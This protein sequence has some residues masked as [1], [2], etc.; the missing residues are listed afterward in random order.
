MLVQPGIL[1]P[2]AH[3]LNTSFGA[4]VLIIGLGQTGFETMALLHDMLRHS[5]SPRDLQVNTRTLAIA[6]RRSMQQE[7]LLHREARL[8]LSIDAIRWSDVPGRYKALGVSRWWPRTPFNLELQEN[9]M[10]TRAF[11][12]LL[13]WHNAQIVGEKL[14]QLTE[15]LQISSQR[16]NQPRLVMV[17]GSLGEAESSGM[18]FDVVGRI[19]ALLA[20][21]P[22]TIAGVF[23]TATDSLDEYERLKTMANAYATLKELDAFNLHPETYRHEFP[24]A[25]TLPEG[26][27]KQALD[28]ICL[29]GDAIMPA[30]YVEG[31]LAEF[32]LT[33]L[34]HLTQK[35]EPFLP[36]LSPQNQ[37]SRYT[38]YTNFGVAKLGLPTRAALELQAI[39]TAR[40][41]LKRLMD[42][43][44]D[45]FKDWTQKIITRAHTDLYSKGLKEHA[46]LADKYRELE[47]RLNSKAIAGAASG[48]KR[49]LRE[50]VGVE[51]QK[52][53]RENIAEE[54]DK[55]GVPIPRDVL[56]RRIN[57][58][59]HK[60]LTSLADSVEKLGVTLAYEQ[61]YGLVWT[62]RLFQALAQQIDEVLYTMREKTQF[63]REDLDEIRDTWLEAASNPRNMDKYLD[64]IIHAATEWISCDARTVYWEEF[65]RLVEE[66]RDKVQQ[67]GQQI[68][69][70]L[71]NLDELSQHLAQN[72]ERACQQRPTFPS[73][74]VASEAWLQAGIQNIPHAESIAPQI[75]IST[76]FGRWDKRDYDHQRQLYRFPGEILDAC[77]LTIQP[78]ARFPNLFD[79]LQ[80]NTHAPPVRHALSTIGASAAPAWTMESVT[81]V[82]NQNFRPP[83]PL[84]IVRET[85]RPNSLIPRS[86]A[87]HVISVT[88]PSPDPDEVVVIRALHGWAAEQARLIRDDYRRAY[89][90]ISAENIPLHIDRR[91]ENTMA[92][93]VH[94][95]FRSEISAIWESVVVDIQSHRPSL[96]QAIHYLSVTIAAAL[97][98]A[99][100]DVQ[101]LSPIVSDIHM[102]TYQMKPFRLM[103]PPPNCA[104][105]FLTSTRS[106]N[107]VR[108]D[109][110][111]VVTMP[112]LEGNF[113]FLIDLTN[114]D[115]IE[116]LLD[117]LREQSFLPLALAEADVKHIVS[118]PRP[119]NALSDIVINRINLT[120]ISPF[121]TRAPVPDHM[122]FGREREIADVRS[123]LTTHS[124]VLL[125]GRRIGKTSTLQKIYRTL[126]SKESKL[127]PYY[128]DCSNVLE[129]RHFFRRIQSEWRLP[130][131]GIQDPILFDEVVE[132]INQQHP[133]RT[134]VF[135]LDEVDRLLKTDQGVGHDEPLFRTFRTL[136]NQKRSQF[137]FSGERLLL[138]SVNN[139]HSVLFNF[140]KT[141][142]LELLHSEVVGRLVREPFEMLNIWLEQPKEIVHHIYEVSAGHP[143]VV[144][145]ICHELVRLID[146]DK[147]SYLLRS[148]H[149]GKA[150]DNH[151]V[152][153]DIAETMW[154]QV[155]SL[156]KLMTLLWP[157][158]VRSMTLE[159][160]M[161]LIKQ[162]GLPNILVADVQEQ[163]IPDLKLYNFIRQVKNEY[164]LIPVYF[165][166]ILDEMTDK[167]IEIHAIV[168]KMANGL[169]D[170]RPNYTG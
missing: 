37:W 124:V 97:E 101:M 16:L 163:V 48:K 117:P 77:R 87:A 152:Q 156:A 66:I 38:G 63:A 74:A 76:I 140:P 94:T 28:Y 161:R 103:L 123:K 81:G 133:G 93:L 4:S 5:Q 86:D 148:E 127:V 90:R 129:H 159:E 31:T 29:T 91:W 131:G 102:F 138:R 130:V 32:V 143:N 64:E 160:M 49:D 84:E 7:Q 25:G 154:G 71:T 23:T 122:F 96:M 20:T 132:L 22:T 113:F 80:T 142:R 99:E 153:T 95:S 116:Y 115:D 162:A 70:T 26:K 54:L 62:Y 68:P 6:Q 56:R 83:Q 33:W 92:D 9:P 69:E 82:L 59:L 11:G 2:R 17:V 67:V 135:L 128:M 1:G 151:D 58:V 75:L 106:T 170:T 104:F 10:L 65:R 45:S 43:P 3:P 19:R 57:E 88:V 166:T 27:P 147:Q 158:N 110:F 125:G 120:A 146:R 85:A 12:R 89:Y 108:E 137:V 34:L 100:K 136:S 109:L 118:A 13:L 150:L 44:S 72:L 30:Q 55:D 42:V 40:V 41:A 144:Q 149:L 18:I 157:E 169:Q 60:G 98:V 21:T 107:E 53:L 168:E 165:P 121:Y 46:H 36:S 51:W 141:V 134:P 73:G 50:M 126:D 52:L 112:M 39:K 114:R 155:G 167:K 119:L 105:V 139:P 111:R 61:G 145:T 35:T 8:L 78:Q 15:W 79:F 24:L 164:W 47:R 14:A